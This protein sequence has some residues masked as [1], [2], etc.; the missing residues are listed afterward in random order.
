MS[1][2][3]P[4]AWAGPRFFD[5]AAS[6]N[7]TAQLPADRA[8]RIQAGPRFLKQREDAAT[9]RG[10]H[11]SHQKTGVRTIQTHRTVA[12]PLRTNHSKAPGRYART[13]RQQ[14]AQ[15]ET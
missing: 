3:V 5:P 12:E 10:T 2:R 8:I 7:A 4:V 1:W 6:P 15:S 11:V 13:R 14:T 9:T